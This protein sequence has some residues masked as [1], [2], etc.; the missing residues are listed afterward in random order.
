MKF[1][2]LFFIL[3]I[4][5]VAFVAAQEDET[6]EEVPPV[7]VEAEVNCDEVCS[8]Q[9]AEATRVANQEKAELEGQLS[10]L[11]AALEQAQQASVAA[12]S[13][14]TSLKGQLASMESVVATAKSEAEAIK[15]SA[16]EL[17]VAGAAKLAEMEAELVAA[18]SKVAE[19]E[20]AR[21]FI[22]KNKIKADF[23]GLLKKYGLVKEE[24]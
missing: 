5:L 21:Y 2:Q 17:E 12:A 4:A 16:A 18:M 15:K 13:D 6:G 11:K 14:V 19:F 8:S 20:S 10:P 23:T 7:Q 9:V 24:L 1:T 3:I 22:N